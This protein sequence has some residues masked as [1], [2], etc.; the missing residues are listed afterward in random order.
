MYVFAMYHQQ[1]RWCVCVCVSSCDRMVQGEQHQLDLNP[2]L[3]S[4]ICFR[5]GKNLC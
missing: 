1:Y 5:K 3:G 2:H 4:A